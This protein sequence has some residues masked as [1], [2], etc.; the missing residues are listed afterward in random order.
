MSTANLPLVPPPGNP[1]SFLVAT[2][3]IQP[4]WD[5][6]FDPEI[7]RK[8]IQ[9]WFPDASANGIDYT[10]EGANAVSQRWYAPFYPD[11]ENT[12]TLP[13]VI[14]QMVSWNRERYGYVGKFCDGPWNIDGSMTRDLVVQ[15]V[16]MTP[17][18]DFNDQMLEQSAL[19]LNKTSHGVL[20][21]NRGGVP[22]K[23][24]SSYGK[25][26]A[27]NITLKNN[28]G[29][30]FLVNNA[31]PV[32][33]GQ[34]WSL[35]ISFGPDPYT[36]PFGYR[37]A[38]VEFKPSMRSEVIKYLTLG[39]VPTSSASGQP[40]FNAVDDLVGGDPSKIEITKT[41][42]PLRN[43][44]IEVAIRY[45]WVRIEQVFN[46]GPI[47]VPEQIK[48]ANANPLVWAK[49]NRVSIRGNYLGCINVDPFLG[50][51]RGYVMYTGAEIE[52][53]QS[54]VSGK[55]GYKISHLF[56]INLSG[57]WNKTPISQDESN[58]II[59]IDE[60]G[61]PVIPR[62]FMVMMDSKNPGKIYKV[63]IGG[64]DASAVYPYSYKTFADLLYYGV[65][66]DGQ[67]FAM[68]G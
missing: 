34:W 18:Y 21:A 60:D 6:N 20:G 65:V 48:S 56:T 61:T 17:K 8:H 4:R 40:D 2:E 54:P 47:G 19:A 29:Q 64:G 38:A 45:P 62:G 66:G 15:S 12:C 53:A 63:D 23:P 44:Q 42:F 24:V 22:I 36:N 58:A 68:E 27:D 37:Y 25:Q 52:D 5:V 50:F 32:M 11:L 55:M 16:R 1:H 13:Q 39:V 3:A 10:V 67:V 14:R 57:E 49:D 51:P 28:A 31:Y 46:A 26:V 59:N 33:V 7:G 30:P 43:G 35:D 41:G 9:S